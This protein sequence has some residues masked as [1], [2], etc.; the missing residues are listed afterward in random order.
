M[1]DMSE[2]LS[3]GGNE[4]AMLLAM[5]FL[6]AAF[7]TKMALFPFHGWQPSAYAHAEVGS[8]P[9]ISGVMGKI[10]AYALFR[11]LYCIYGKEYEYFGIIIKGQ[12]LNLGY[13][14]YRSAFC[15]L[16]DVRLD[17]SDGSD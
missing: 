12:S 13:S 6:V 16:D 3:R 10:P 1:M 5:C 11:Y 8:R 9:L 14:D 4:S 17:K 15:M 7:A 2:I